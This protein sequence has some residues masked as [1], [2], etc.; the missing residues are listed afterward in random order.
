MF[1][2]GV[3]PSGVPPQ[4]RPTFGLLEP[5][6]TDKAVP[7][8]PAKDRSWLT[9][10]SECLVDA[11]PWIRV[12]REIVLLNDLSIV[13][14]YHRIEM[15]DHVVVFPR[16]RDGMV[17]TLHQYKHGLNAETITLPGGSFEDDEQPLEAARRELLE[18]T[19]LASDQWYFLGTFRQHGNYDCGDG[20]YFLASDCRFVDSIRS[21][22]LETAT[23]HWHHPD[24]LCRQLHH[25]RIDLMHHAFLIAL[26]RSFESD[27]A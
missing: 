12:N 6:T 16:T 19:G 24:Q 20:H 25:G 26:V 15:P 27:P 13:E 5:T 3:L 17:A 10:R 22:D 8:D 9:L 18:E 11:S 7:E 14:D 23:L 1:K 2:P 4:D 21:G